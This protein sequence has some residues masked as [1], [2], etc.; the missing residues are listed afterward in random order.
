[1]R[2]Q[3]LISTLIILQ[4][5]IL[6]G[7][8][9]PTSGTSSEETYSPDIEFTAAAETI[10]PKL[11]PTLLPT[12]EIPIITI[13]HS[14]PNPTSS[15]EPTASKIPA[16]TPAATEVREIIYADDF[17]DKTSWYTYEGDRFSFIYTDDGYHIYNDI[18][19]GLIWSIREQD[20]SGVALEVDGTRLQGPEGSYVGVVCKFANDGENYYALVIGDNGFYGFGLMEGGEYEFIETGMDD[21]SVI[22]NG[23][24]ATNRIRGICNGNQYLIYANGE[25]LLDVWDC[26][27]E[28]GIIGLVVGNQ[29]TGSGSEFRF[30]DFVITWP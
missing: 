13:T 24:G 17:S 23:Q 11:S 7:C 22:L 18:K 21:K 14:S 27:L 15:Q 16:E 6:S 5:L 4:I 26:T 1:M 2:K 3:L 28:E 19:M 8:N 9:L 12:T 29:R 10:Q 20:Y 25:L 30:N